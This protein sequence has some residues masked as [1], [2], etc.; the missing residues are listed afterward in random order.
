[1][2]ITQCKV[3]CRP[4][5]ISIKSESRV[6]S[7]VD[8]KDRLVYVKSSWTGSK[9]YRFSC[10]ATQNF[11]P[12]LTVVAD[13]FDDFEPPSK[14][15]LATPL[16]CFQHDVAISRDFKDLHRRAASDKVLDKALNIAKNRKY[17]ELQ[18]SFRSMVYNFVQKKPASTQWN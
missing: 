13:I 9:I 10:S 12:R 6:S 1:M 4:V 17:D 15:F 14:K 16:V 3:L 5:H 18:E 11:I 8:K 7:S 2:W